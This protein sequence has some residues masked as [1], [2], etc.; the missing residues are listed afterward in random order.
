MNGTSISRTIRRSERGTAVVEFAL[1]L[2]LL[3]MFLFGIMEFGRIMMVN[4][5][6]NNAARA[7]ARIAVL[8]G[9]DNDRVLSAIN[10]ELSSCGL[11]LDEY[12]LDPSDVSTAER[13]DPI[14]VTIK[15]DYES[16]GFVTGFFPMLTGKQLQGT[17]VMRKEGFS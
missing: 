16:I 5:T 10:S 9:S 8:P 14:T 3:L 12:V 13:D 6:L 1:V 2:P 4:H 15:I 17:V 11:T 7:G